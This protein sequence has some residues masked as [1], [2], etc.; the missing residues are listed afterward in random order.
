MMV[1]HILHGIGIGL[2]LSGG[3][4]ALGVIAATVAPQWQR[5]CR[6]A[7]G[8]VEPSS[9]PLVERAVR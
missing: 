6:L 3:A 2:F 9:M 4:T 1:Q 5:I 7:L 8:N